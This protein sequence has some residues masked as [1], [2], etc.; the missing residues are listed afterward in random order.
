MAHDANDDANQFDLIELKEFAWDY[1]ILND[2]ESLKKVVSMMH[3]ED[4][5]DLFT[6]FQIKEQAKATL[7][8]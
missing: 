1:L 2:S 3:S 4:E 8:Y 5:Q 7:L 6:E